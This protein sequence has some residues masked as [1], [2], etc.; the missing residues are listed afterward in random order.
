MGYREKPYGFSAINAAQKMLNCRIYGLSKCRY[1]GIT[2]IIND[3]RQ[4][5]KMGVFSPKVG[6]GGK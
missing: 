3:L 2:L 4:Y 1:Y 6:V 5:G